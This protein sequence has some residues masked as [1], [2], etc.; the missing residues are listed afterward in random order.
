MRR[1]SALYAIGIILIWFLNLVP[2]YS[3]N[4]LDPESEY[5]R[6][7]EIAFSGDYSTAAGEARKLVNS[8]PAYGDARILLGRIMAWQKDYAN[9][10]AVIDTLLMTEPGNEDALAVKRDITLWSKDNSPVST[11]VRA[12]Y[13]FDTFSDPYSRYWQVFNVGAGHKFNWGPAAAGVNVG[14]LIGGPSPGEVTELQFEVEAYPKLTNKNYAYLAYAYSPGKYF[15]QHRAAVEIWQVL[16]AGFAV[17]AGLNYYYFDKNIFIAMASLEK[18]SGKYW[19]SL[20][21]FVY[22]KDNGPTTSFYINARRYFKD[23]NYLQ[24]TLGTGTAPD[25]PFDLQTNIM[26]F[27]AHSIRLAYNHYLSSRLVMRLNVGYSR[28]EYEDAV[29]RNRFEGGINFIYAIKMK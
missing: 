6:I 14:N 9:A 5:L 7:K 17:S 19:F 24:L 21:G 16:P 15:P 29:W 11:D 23:K 1:Q 27:H 22:F 13:N 10:A 26:R 12:G 4:T 28:E 3:Q 25:E 20:K 18:Y 8:F 2:V